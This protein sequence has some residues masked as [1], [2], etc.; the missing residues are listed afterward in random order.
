[1]VKHFRSSQA[2]LEGLPIDFGQSLIVRFNNTFQGLDVLLHNLLKLI[3]V[4]FRS[5]IDGRMFK[6]HSFK[7]PTYPGRKP[8]LGCE[9]YIPPSS[10]DAHLLRDPPNRLKMPQFRSESEHLNKEF[11]LPKD[12]NNSNSL[13]LA[14]LLG[15]RLQPR[16]TIIPC[17]SKSAVGE[18][19]LTAKPTQ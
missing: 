9:A 6:T 18:Y 10:S 16:R 8:T 19:N 2:L 12:H 5:P 11:R 17:S 14:T 3:P 4:R 15:Y 13:L 7:S 1:M